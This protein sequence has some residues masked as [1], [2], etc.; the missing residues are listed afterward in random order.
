MLTKTKAIQSLIDGAG[1]EGINV[2][3][4]RLDPK[5]CH[6]LAGDIA[7]E[8]CPLGYVNEDGRNLDEEASSLQ[9]LLYNLIFD[10]DHK[11]LLTEKERMEAQEFYL[12]YL[13][14]YLTVDKMAE[15]KNMPVLDVIDTINIGR[16]YHN[17]N[18]REI[19]MIFWVGRDSDS[20]IWGSYPVVEEGYYDT[21]TDAH[22]RAMKL[23]DEQPPEY[24]KDAGENMRYE[25]VRI[26]NSLT[27]KGQK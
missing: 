9:K 1:I 10:Y 11:Q 18:T 7:F 24:D 17:Q 15:H 5:G 13:N 26:D 20:G 16:W 19:Y 27:K 22:L 23:N 2:K 12:E 25:V 14:D 21:H 8:L 6:D 3:D 4:Y